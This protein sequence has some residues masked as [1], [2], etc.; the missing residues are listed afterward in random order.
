MTIG[1]KVKNL[2][3]VTR[4]LYTA[5]IGDEERVPF[6]MSKKN[7]FLLLGNKGPLPVDLHFKAGLRHAREALITINAYLNNTHRWN[8][9]R[10]YSK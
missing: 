2:T 6:V 1:H 8:N 5:S 4:F 7:L 10:H 9:G 3:R